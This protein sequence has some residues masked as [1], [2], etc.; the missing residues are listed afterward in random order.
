MPWRSEASSLL[1]Y[2]SS[3]AINPSLTQVATVEQNLQDPEVMKFM[4]ASSKVCW[5]LPKK[6]YYRKC[7]LDLFLLQL[8]NPA[9]ALAA[10]DADDGA[11][12]APWVKQ[13][14]PPDLRMLADCQHS[15]DHDTSLPDRGQP[16]RLCGCSAKQPLLWPNSASGCSSLDLA[17]PLLYPHRFIKTD[18][19]IQEGTC[20]CSYSFPDDA[21]HQVYKIFGSVSAALGMSPPHRNAHS[22]LDQGVSRFRGVRAQCHPMR[23]TRYHSTLPLWTPKSWQHVYKM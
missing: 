4:A 2:T 18:H 10:S 20:I 5:F 6:T 16:Q 3:D 19:N 21:L 15:V 1:W 12:G 8:W 9:E 11:G 17:Y 22:A 7:D 23:Y 14:D 13:Y